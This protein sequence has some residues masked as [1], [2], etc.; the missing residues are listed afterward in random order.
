MQTSSLVILGCRNHC[1]DH[2]FIPMFLSLLPMLL[3][4][5]MY[6]ILLL[7]WLVIRKKSGKNI[8]SIFGKLSYFAINWRFLEPIV[9]R[10][11]LDTRTDLD[12]SPY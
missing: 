11:L 9:T 12:S 5:Q 6:Q 2:F 3:C 8:E 7:L 10:C 1:L 4:L